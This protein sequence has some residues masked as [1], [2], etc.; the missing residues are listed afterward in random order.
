MPS[1]AMAGEYDEA[2]C[3]MG[4]IEDITGDTGA[5]IGACACIACGLG[6]ETSG[7]GWDDG[8]DGRGAGI[9]ENEEICADAAGPGSGSATLWLYGAGAGGG[10]A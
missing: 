10:G 6:E 3:P 8:I 4:D 5:P 9:V 7:G 1:C 2:Y